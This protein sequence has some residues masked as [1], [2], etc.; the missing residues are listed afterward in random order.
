[1]TQDR[2]PKYASMMSQFPKIPS[3]GEDFNLNK[4]DHWLLLTENL[5]QVKIC[6]GSPIPPKIAMSY[7]PVDQ[8]HADKLKEKLLDNGYVV[9]ARGCEDPQ[10][11]ADLDG[12]EACIVL[13]SHHYVKEYACEGQFTY[14]KDSAESLKL[15]QVMIHSSLYNQTMIYQGP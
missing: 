7:S 13:L 11:F 5:P 3:A 15:I 9:V 12:C 1:M 6:F 2:I 8:Y 10:W 4:R 14:A